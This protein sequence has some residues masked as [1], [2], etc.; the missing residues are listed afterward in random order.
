MELTPPNIAQQHKKVDLFLVGIVLARGTLYF[1]R[2]VS[3]PQ[4]DKRGQAAD[5]HNM[6]GDSSK[7]RWDWH[8]WPD[9]PDYLCWH[10][11]HGNRDEKD[12]VGCIFRDVDWT[13]LAKRLLICGVY[14]Y[15]SAKK[16]A[17]IA[18]LTRRNVQLG[19]ELNSPID[20]RKCFMFQGRR[21]R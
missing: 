2:L 6:R 4:K 17:V 14:M 16:D 21:V 7:I 19:A 20:S 10:V 11:H 3:K 8:P 5:P 18:R 9:P 15:R 13:Y 12:A 1:A